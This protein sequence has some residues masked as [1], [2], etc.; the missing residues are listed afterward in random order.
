MN[1]YHL[2]QLL[3]YI[4]TRNGQDNINAIKVEKIF[5]ET[6][7]EGSEFRYSATGAYEDSVPEASLFYTKEQ[8]LESWKELTNKRAE[9]M[10]DR[11][12]EYAVK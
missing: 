7:F 9:R 10:L 12:A 6:N 4:E 2:G 3:F 5:Q 8:C 11:M 1:K